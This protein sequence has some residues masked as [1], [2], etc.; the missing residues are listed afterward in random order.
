MLAFPP[1]VILRLAQ[2]DRE[3]PVTPKVEWAMGSRG[4][5]M[6]VWTLREDRA[7]GVQ[8][9]LRPA[10]CGAPAVAQRRAAGGGAGLLRVAGAADPTEEVTK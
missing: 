7:M 6:T 2:R 1:F 3:D 4:G 9:R 8:P 10:E 5:A